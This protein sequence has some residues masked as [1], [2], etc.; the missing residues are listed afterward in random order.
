MKVFWK[1]VWE[2]K[3]EIIGYL[4]ILCSQIGSSGLVE[5]STAGWMLFVSGALTALV[6]HVQRVIEYRKKMNILP[7]PQPPRDSL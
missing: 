3:M 4:S 7:P 2:F 5:Q 6:A 1:W